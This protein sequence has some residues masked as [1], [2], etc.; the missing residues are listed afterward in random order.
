ML[1]MVLQVLGC[2]Y[3][4][5]GYSVGF[6]AS[7]WTPGK[8]FEEASFWTQ[9]LFVFFW[10]TRAVTGV[11]GEAPPPQN[12]LEDGFMFIVAFFL[13]F[14]AAAIVASVIDLVKGV[15]A[16]ASAHQLQMSTINVFMAQKNISPELQNRVRAHFIS[17]HSRAKGIK[18]K[19]ME[20]IKDL[21]SR[22]RSQVAMQMNGDILKK[23]PLFVGAE[24]AFLHELAQRLEE[25][26]FAPGDV[27]CEEGEEGDEMF[28]VS[29]G[30]VEI[31]LH[32]DAETN[33]GDVV[34]SLSE[35]AYFGEISLLTGGARTA[36]VRAANYCTIY[37]LSKRDLDAATTAFPD[38]RRKLA[39]MAATRQARDSLL[40]HLGNIPPVRVAFNAIKPPVGEEAADGDSVQESL[41][42]F[43]K[44]LINEFVPMSVQPGDVLLSEG[45]A[46]DS[47]PTAYADAESAKPGSLGIYFLGSGTV[48]VLDAV[49]VIQRR[50][51][52]RTARSEAAVL[53]FS[54]CVV[55]SKCQ[56][57][58]RVSAPDTVIF[59]CPLD[60]F[61]E[62]LEAHL[63]GPVL[64][65]LHANAE[66]SLADRYCYVFRP[67]SELTRS[68]AELWRIATVRIRA[69]LTLSRSRRRA[70]L[71]DL[72]AKQLAHGRTHVHRRDWLF[73]M[74]ALKRDAHWPKEESSPDSMIKFLDEKQLI[75]GEAKSFVFARRI[76]RHL[77]HP[78]KKATRKLGRLQLVL[79][80]SICDKLENPR[81]KHK[82]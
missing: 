18:A 2:A 74:R 51:L 62:V 34:A 48:D 46:V 16:E 73:G 65:A 58:F 66:L 26:I 72:T 13:L 80:E 20:M 6:G 9:W 71:E 25:E 69:V 54:E 3:I 29:R 61:R 39:S 11:G 44:A 24:H 45:K 33:S 21:P 22:L 30:S 82:H 10:A 1:L 63:P 52:V 79:A 67:K 43:V 12:T 7:R 23:V 15:R 60:K 31:V 57:T 70:S 41:D 64:K 75:E 8:D 77:T 17:Q 40:T 81:H 78:R 27:I 76:V 42:A 47:L 19:P 49:D 55:G 14:V 35:G 56:R 38:E 59:F 36:T 37:V 32:Y 4:A 50:L 5:V 28:F 68:G 53:G